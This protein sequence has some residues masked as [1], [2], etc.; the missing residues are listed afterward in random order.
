MI[1]QLTLGV[2]LKDEATFVNYDAV[3]NGPLI[4]ELKK[5]ASG[6]GERV[7]YFCG[8]GGQ[9]CTHLLQASCHEATRHQMTSVYIPLRNLI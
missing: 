1:D 5:T 7:I 2:G 8:I 9:G 3:Q 4:H 6:Q